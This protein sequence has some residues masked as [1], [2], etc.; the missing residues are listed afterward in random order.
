MFEHVCFRPP[1]D[2]DDRIEVESIRQD[3]ETNGYD[4]IDIFADVA[5]YCSE[6]L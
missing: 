2:L 6:D 4:M 3:F 1:S 5:T